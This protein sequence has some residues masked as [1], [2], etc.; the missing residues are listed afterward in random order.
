VTLKARLDV[1]A[2]ETRT[3]ADHLGLL[4]DHLR[5]RL[6]ATHGLVDGASSADAHALLVA[7]GSAGQQLAAAVQSLETASRRL[8]EFIKTL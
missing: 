3:A 4:A 1:A 6:E 8:E 5:R 2:A 7:L